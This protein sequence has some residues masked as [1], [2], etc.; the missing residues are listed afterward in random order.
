MTP[1][2]DVR[3]ID[4]ARPLAHVQDVL[5][6]AIDCAPAD[7]P[8]LLDAR[9]GDDAALRSEV[10]SLLAAHERGGSWTNLPRP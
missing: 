6:D 3:A 2:P 4:R 8:A 7:R 10:D 9:C 1:S 5:A